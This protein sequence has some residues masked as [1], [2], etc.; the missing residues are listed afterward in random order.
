MYQQVILSDGDLSTLAN[1]KSNLKLNHLNIELEIPE[2]DRKLDMVKCMHL[3]WESASENQLEDVIP[4]I[5]LGADVIYDPLCLPHLIRV[6]SILLSRK[7]SHSCRQVGSCD[8]IAPNSEHENGELH[9]SNQRNCE[10]LGDRSAI[11]GTFI[12]NH[13]SSD[14]PNE[15]PLAYIACV[16][17][18]IETFNQFLSLADEAKLDVVDQIDSLKPLN[19]LPYMHSYN[20][21]SIRLLRITRNRLV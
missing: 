2:R 1:M 20:Q 4:D 19:L 3:P 13:G 8:G 5:V 7:K 6:I 11:S 15:A 21:A 17:R 14:G 16:V 18:N 10:G 9:H 12:N